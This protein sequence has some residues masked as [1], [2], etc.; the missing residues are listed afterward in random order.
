[1]VPVAPLRGKLARAARLL[2]EYQQTEREFIHSDA[3]DARHS[4][5]GGLLVEVK[6]VPDSLSAIAGD[7]LQDLRSALDHE[8]HRIAEASKGKGWSG[9][10]KCAF[11]LHR[12]DEGR[13][14]N[15]REA[16]IGALPHAVKEVIDSV[17]LFRDPRDPEADSLEL[18]NELARR[19]RHR[20]LHLTAIQVT[21][22]ETEVVPPQ[23]LTGKLIGEI[24]PTT[25][26]G[27]KVRMK[28]RVA[29]AEPPAKAKPVAETLVELALTVK[30]V[31]GRM[32]Q[33]EMTG[34]ETSG[35]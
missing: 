3:T 24:T 11:P 13:Y 22:V 34:S 23:D 29:F 6:L 30:Q 16:M 31:L 10:D 35:P 27:V 32:R 4:E 12:V 26:H 33:A 1:M 7:V 19:D 25:T 21:G 5:V 20:L 17:Q 28:M 15:A 9:L 14:A 2:L 8:V 18:L